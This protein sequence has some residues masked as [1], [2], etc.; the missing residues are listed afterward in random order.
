MGKDKRKKDGSRK[1]EDPSVPVD[2]ASEPKAHRGPRN[3]PSREQ[4]QKDGNR[5]VDI[6][7]QDTIS[8]HPPLQPDSKPGETP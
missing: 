8:D 3:R 4:S 7:L 2:I 1:Q 6:S 5:S